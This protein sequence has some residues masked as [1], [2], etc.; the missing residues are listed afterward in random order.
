MKCIQTLCLHSTLY[1]G[2]SATTVQSKYTSVPSRMLSLL[3]EVPRVSLVSGTSENK[4][5]AE[6]ITHIE[7]ITK[8]VQFVS[9]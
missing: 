8:A 5:G 4:K 2:G 6:N 3:S 9:L 1:T 7:T